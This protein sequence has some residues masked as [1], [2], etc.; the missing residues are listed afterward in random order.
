MSL[1]LVIDTSLRQGSHCNFTYNFDK[2][3]IERYSTI[4]LNCLY[5]YHEN[6]VNKV[7]NDQQDT[8]G[9]R[10]FLKPL[11]VHCSL[12]NKDYN[13]FNGKK[14]DVLAVIYPHM[15]SPRNYTTN[16]VLKIDSTQSKLIYPR[17]YMQ[18]K[19]T[20]SNG[21]VV[22]KRGKFY[23]VYEFQFSQ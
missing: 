15:Y 20:H 1:S 11:H 12:L 19:L 18:I 22:E 14:S 16:F 17:S 10:F 8:E 6:D 2:L 23:V 9:T 4:K 21:D 5:I 7:F 3:N 13:F